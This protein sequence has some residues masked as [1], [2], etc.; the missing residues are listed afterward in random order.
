V[1]LVLGGSVVLAGANITSA[2][3]PS[4]E[5][6]LMLL[7]PT[8]H[9]A[10]TLEQTLRSV[11]G[12]PDTV[13][14]S[15]TGQE[16][17]DSM[18]ESTLVQYVLG[19]VCL[20]V[21]RF[22]LAMLE[23]EG[24][25]LARALRFAGADAGRT[26]EAYLQARRFVG[27]S[28][29]PFPGPYGGFVAQAGWRPP[30]VRFGERLLYDYSAAGDGFYAYA[31]GDTIFEVYADHPFVDEIIGL[32]PGPDIDSRSFGPPVEPAPHDCPGADPGLRR[33][34]PSSLGDIDLD[35]FPLPPGLTLGLEHDMLGTM[36]DPDSITGY[37]LFVSLSS[38]A[39]AYRIP[40]GD[41]AKL[42]KVCRR[43]LY[44]RKKDVRVVDWGGRTVIV[45]RERTSACYVRGDM[46]FV[47]SS[48]ALA[49]EFIRTIP[50]LEDP[51][52]GAPRSPRPPD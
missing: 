46:I 36:D 8:D 42:A 14:F 41:P 23:S 10:V 50:L 3:S 16:A 44:L 20:G 1:A 28:V 48:P 38:S 5:P 2:A 15:F 6:D 21:D 40:E 39:T 25:S 49:K 19:S 31:V 45:D 43:A 32:L 29:E 4:P 47:I 35:P 26:L 51:S 13:T 34:L 30:R 24:G 7:F 33:L 9:Q 52:D 11:S 18:Y 22:A 17:A 12:G 37:L 27:P